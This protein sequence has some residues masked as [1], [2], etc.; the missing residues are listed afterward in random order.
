VLTDEL[1][2]GQGQLNM[3]TRRSRRK[4]DDWVLAM[5]VFNQS[6]SDEL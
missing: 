2:D 3:D 6:N 4:R 5:K 1:G